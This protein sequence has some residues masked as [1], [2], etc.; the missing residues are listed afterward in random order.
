MWNDIK[1]KKLKD[2]E[3][4]LQQYHFVHHES[5]MNWPW[6]ELGPPNRSYCLLKQVALTTRLY[7]FNKSF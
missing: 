6:R 1:R 3:R 7:G 5:L 2:S 4:D